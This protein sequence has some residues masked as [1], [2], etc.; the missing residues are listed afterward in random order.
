MAWDIQLIGTR[1][2]VLAALNAM[3]FQTGSAEDQQKADAVVLIKTAI[4]GGG[5]GDVS[6][7]FFNQ[8]PVTVKA[9]GYVTSNSN[10]CRISVDA[11]TLVDVDAVTTAGRVTSNGTPPALPEASVVTV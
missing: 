1:T 2:Y 4:G 7:I 11:V 10:N 5:T 8:G 9:H 3:Q 6:G